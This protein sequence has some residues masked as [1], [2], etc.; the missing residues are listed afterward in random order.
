M[1]P[2]NLASGTS[3]TISINARVDGDI[4]GTITNRAEI[5]Q[6]D[7]DD[8]DSTPDFDQFNDIFSGNDNIS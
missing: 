1:I 6:D 4:T 5:S 2:I 3:Q 8:I 7:G